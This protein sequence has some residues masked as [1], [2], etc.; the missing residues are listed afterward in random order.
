MLSLRPLRRRRGHPVG[1]PTSADEP[2]AV[3]ASPS[4]RAPSTSARHAATRAPARSKRVS[5]AARRAVIRGSPRAFDKTPGARLQLELSPATWTPRTPSAAPISATRALRLPQLLR[6]H[7][8]NLLVHDRDANQGNS[9]LGL[10]GTRALLQDLTGAE[11]IPPG[12]H[13][14]LFKI[15]MK[16]R[17]GGRTEELRR[18]VEAARPPSR[19]RAPSVRHTDFRSDP[20]LQ[21][22]MDVTTPPVRRIPPRRSDEHGAS[23]EST[24]GDDTAEAAAPVRH[25]LSSPQAGFR[26]ERMGVWRGA[27]ET[28][29]RVGAQMAAF[30]GFPLLSRRPTRL[31]YIVVITWPMALQESATPFS[32]RSPTS[33]SSPTIPAVL[34]SSTAFKEDPLHYFLTEYAPPGRRS[35]PPLS[36]PMSATGGPPSP[37]RRGELSGCGRCL[38]SAGTRSSHRRVEGPYLWDVDGNLL[39]D[40]SPPGTR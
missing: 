40:W 1:T 10:E 9:P 12:C 8:F 24:W 38:A 25:P 39:R 2:H 19:A 27:R 11:S 33:T 37:P 22:P 29:P 21:G 28:D 36:A 5:S 4:T 35:T 14:P 34:Y 15:N 7:E 13:A 26:V 31:A 23:S 17:D 6:P 18:P 20:A 32:T 3:R 16:P 30:A